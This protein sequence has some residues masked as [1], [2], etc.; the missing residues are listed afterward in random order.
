MMER[1][2]ALQP[3]CL[4][5]RGKDLEARACTGNRANVR[6]FLDGSD[7]NLD[8]ERDWLVKR[9]QR[10]RGGTV[11]RRPK[12]CPPPPRTLRASFPG[13]RAPNAQISPRQLKSNR[14]Q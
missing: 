6:S 10:N 4:H 13:G 7:E 9:H 11:W 2:P 1:D 5:R 3:R 14:A 12:A 8:R